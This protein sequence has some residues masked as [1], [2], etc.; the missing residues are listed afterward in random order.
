ML[1]LLEQTFNS[2]HVLAMR[3]EPCISLSAEQQRSLEDLANLVRE[4]HRQLARTPLPSGSREILRHQGAERT[5]C[6][7]MDYTDGDQL[8]TSDVVNHGLQ[9]QGNR[10][11]IQ[12]PLTVVFREI[13]QAICRRRAQRIPHSKQERRRGSIKGSFITLLWRRRG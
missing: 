12:F 11:P 7:A 8:R 6:P 4:R 1:P 2:G 13:F 9:H 10:H 5:L 3:E